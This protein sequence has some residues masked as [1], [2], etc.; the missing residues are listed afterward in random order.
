[1][2]STV[3]ETLEDAAISARRRVS[4][5][6]AGDHRRYHYGPPDRVARA[7]GGGGQTPDDEMFEGPSCLNGGESMERVAGN[8]IF[9]EI[10]GAQ[11]RLLGREDWQSWEMWKRDAR[12]PG[13]AGNAFPRGAPVS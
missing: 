9:L 7:R 2:R 8:K 4:R 13:I 12:S 5:T 10:L 1:M 3:F 6:P 11:S